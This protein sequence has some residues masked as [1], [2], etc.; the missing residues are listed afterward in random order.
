M[1]ISSD[2]IRKEFGESD[3]RRDAGLTTPD[4]I[5]RYDDI[6]YGK[7]RTWQLLDVYRPKNCKGRR[8][9]VIVSVHGGGWVYGDKDVYQ[10]YCMSLAQRGFA[11]VNFTYRL[12]PEYKFPAP[13]EDTNMVFEWVLN[14][15]EEYGLDT[16]NIFAVGDSAGAQ[17]L[18]LY[19][20]IYANEEYALNYDFK[21]P[22]ELRIK[23]IALNCG[24]YDIDSKND[25][26]G[27]RGELMKDYLPGGGTREE[28]VAMNV[29]YHMTEKFPPTF[30]MT[31]T[32][33]FLIP[34]AQILEGA[35]IN[36]AV[37]HEFHFYGSYEKELGHVFH[38]NVKTDEARRCNDDEC[39]YFNRFIE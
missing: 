5:E 8:L 36:N 7:D 19:A 29:A 2:K 32:G 25:Y 3:A 12:A 27:M 31:C 16:E 33:D 17:T 15:C 6:L 9:P 20:D 24:V 14:N 23:A 37:P 13:I 26:D 30:Y 21:V 1:S 35:L 39:R 4:D 18:G 28:L 34:Q 11:V 10:H 22:S 38:C